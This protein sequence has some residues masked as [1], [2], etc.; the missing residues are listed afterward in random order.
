MARPVLFI[1]FI[2]FAAGT[3]GWTS[4]CAGDDNADACQDKECQTP[5]APFCND[6]GMLVTYGE[7]GTCQFDRCA[8]P[9]Q[10][11]ACDGS[12]VCLEGECVA[13]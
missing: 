5:P 9:A 12:M 8:Y 7:T 10:I 6:A 1:W 11:I 4:G 3:A 13:T 2:L